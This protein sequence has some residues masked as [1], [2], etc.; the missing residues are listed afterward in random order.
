MLAAEKSEIKVPGDCREGDFLFSPVAIAIAKCDQLP[1]S[2]LELL[3]ASF[4]RQLQALNRKQRG[5]HGW[6]FEMS[7]CSSLTKMFATWYRVGL[8]RSYKLAVRVQSTNLYIITLT[9]K[10]CRKAM[11]LMISSDV[12]SL[13]LTGCAGLMS[14]ARKPF[15]RFASILV[16]VGDES[17]KYST[18]LRF[19]SHIDRLPVFHNAI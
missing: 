7:E 8:E 11:T 12:G 17:Q 2:R 10:S 15:V 14:Q 18:Q 1:V 16:T 9:C 5:H 3:K 13:G 19:L 6:H 4:K